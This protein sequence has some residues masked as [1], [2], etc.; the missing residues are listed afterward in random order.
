MPPRARGRSPAHHCDPLCRPAPDSSGAAAA[1][2]G[3]EG[4]PSRQSPGAA[5]PTS[6][7]LLYSPADASPAEGGKEEL[8]AALRRVAELT[9]ECAGLNEEAAQLRRELAEEKAAHAD[10]R[11]RTKL[12]FERMAEDQAAQQQFAPGSRGRPAAS[13]ASS[14]PKKGERLRNFFTKR[15]HSSPSRADTQPEVISPMT[16]PTGALMQDGPRSRRHCSGAPPV[17]PSWQGASTSHLAA[18]S[19]P[20]APVDACSVPLPSPGPGSP[21]A[22]FSLSASGPRPIEV[23]EDEER[24]REL[25]SRKGQL[26]AATHDLRKLQGDLESDTAKLRGEREHLQG[27]VERT[28]RLSVQLKQEQDRIRAQLTQQRQLLAQAQR[29]AD[30][31]A[32][33]SL[34]LSGDSAGGGA[35]AAASKEQARVAAQLAWALAALDRLLPGVKWDTGKSP[36]ADDERLLGSCV[37]PAARLDALC[38][39]GLPPPAAR[40]GPRCSTDSQPRSAARLRPAPSGGGGSEGGSSARSSSGD[41]R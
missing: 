32:G 22:G 26:E 15:S 27:E 14:G 29:Q 28:E 7:G 8:A 1:V 16:S 17:D 30:V 9:A 12:I 39:L 41:L 23:L 25:K 5:A 2:D 24:V 34:R 3:A 31:A 40:N 13:A 20:G 21:V 35:G 36:P 11:E 38:P 37:L 19:P 6:P 18:D 4:S 33:E 10:T